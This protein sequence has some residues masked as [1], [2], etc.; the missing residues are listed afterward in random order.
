[1]KEILL[2]YLL[3]Y[4]QLG[5]PGIGFVQVYIRASQTDIVNKRI[6]PPT[7]A[8]R[9]TPEIPVPAHHDQVRFIS[10][11]MQVSEAVAERQLD[12][13]C[14]AAV[15]GIRKGVPLEWDGFGI[16]R[17]GIAGDMTFD[18]TSKSIFAFPPV[19]AERVIHP[20]A[21]HTIQVGDTEKTNTEMAEL[22]QEEASSRRRSRWWVWALILAVI[23]I[24]VLAYYMY[25][26]NGHV[27]AFRNQQA[28]P[29]NTP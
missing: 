11:S 1:M 26:H 3:Q 24:T 29:Q 21:E 25:D 19:A 23:G 13:F 2:K 9:I 22:L 5:L 16:I 7:P 18:L 6:L 27:D 4:Q 14:T 12:D 17:K 15:E 8:A 28:L 10:R 20:N